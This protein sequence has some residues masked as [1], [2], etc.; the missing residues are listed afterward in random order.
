M[1]TETVILRP[2]GIYTQSTSSILTCYPSDVASK[3]QYLLVC[4]EVA[5][6][7]A[8][9]VIISSI[10]FSFGFAIPTEYVGKTPSSIKIFFRQKLE[11]A[12]TSASLAIKLG[13][14]GSNS[15]YYYNM[16]NYSNCDNITTEVPVTTEYT[17]LMVNVPRDNLSQLVF[18]ERSTHIFVG[19]TVSGSGSKSA[20]PRTTQI[21]IELTYGDEPETLKTIYLKENGSWVS[22]PCTIYQKQNGAW[23]ETDATVFEDGNQYTFQE[24][25]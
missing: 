16:T 10:L 25:A 9:Y 13:A 4:E 14:V 20:N 6:D 17:S 5:D 15:E 22:V 2:D 21:Y 3:E 12:G 18:D 8:S 19:H 23:I 7:D 11:N 24:L 1:A